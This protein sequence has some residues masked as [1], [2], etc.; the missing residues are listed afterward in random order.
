MSYGTKDIGG[1]LSVGRNLT[2]GGNVTARG[3]AR[4][5]HNL[6]VD[7]WLEAPN[8]VGPLK[9][10]YATAESLRGAYP[11]PRPG[12]YA[13]VGGTLPAAVYRADR[14]ERGKTVWAATGETGGEFVLYP[15]RIEREVGELRDDVRGLEGR[16]LTGAAFASEETYGTLSLT[17]PDGTAGASVTI[18]GM[19][20]GKAG[21][22]T[23]TRLAAIRSEMTQ[24][25]IDA[26]L[27]VSYETFDDHGTLW[28]TMPSGNRKG[29]GIPGMTEG[30]A[31][32]LTP[33][34]LESLRSEMRTATADSVTGIEVEQLDTFARI[35][36]TTQGGRRSIATL[37][38]AMDGE[39]AGLYSPTRHRQVLGLIEK[40]SADGLARDSEAVTF[41][42]EETYGRVWIKRADGTLASAVVPGMTDGKAGLMTPTRLAALRSEIAQTTTDAIASGTYE[43]FEAHGTIWLTLPS[44]NRKGIGIPG[45]S[46]GK[47]GLLTPARLEAIRAE[48]REASGPLATRLSALEGLIGADSDGRINR[49]NEIVSFLA[50]VEDTETL[51]GILTGI[52]TQAA[53]K[54]DKTTTDRALADLRTLVTEAEERLSR[55]NAELRSENAELRE[56][57]A[58]TDGRLEELAETLQ[59]RI[60]RNETAIELTA[61][62]AA[63]DNARLRAETGILPFDGIAV[64]E[65][66]ATWEA[67]SEGSTVYLTE[68]GHFKMKSDRLTSALAD[69]NEEGEDGAILA[70]RDR[71][72]RMGNRLYSFDGTALAAEAEPQ[73]ISEEEIAAAV[74]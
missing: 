3:N 69:Y 4:V 20:E 65:E 16:L 33:A 30:K 31:G 25:A 49:F 64:N 15:D 9:G 61:T 72:F 59:A 42:S 67:L 35:W 45:M 10:L 55:E 73:S 36:S 6:R 27:G 47:A 17:R 39:T 8:I 48:I 54:A 22:M 2:A 52:A 71:L 74:G 62:E 57:L 41:T 53:A 24:T 44:G 19:T 7:G 68:A 13:L 58:A 46:E 40:A 29:V 26:L 50:G 1:D 66:D 43:A 70:R 32:L 5:G 51:E 18:P 23:P 14:D 60:G 37:L 38:T 56:R 34:R 11:E 12:W 21:L 28:L 63:T